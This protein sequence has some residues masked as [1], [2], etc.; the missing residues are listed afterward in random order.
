MWTVNRPADIKR[1][2]AKGADGIISD[3]SSQVKREIKRLRNDKKSL[4]LAKF[5]VILNEFGYGLRI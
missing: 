2:L 4:R 5:R 3:D 1:V